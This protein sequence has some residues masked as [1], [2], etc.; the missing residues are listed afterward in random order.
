MKISVCIPTYEA[1]GKGVE[2][3][4]KNIQ[5]ILDQTYKNIEIVVSDHS[6]DD[7]IENYVKSIDSENIKYLRYTENIGYP[8]YNTNNAIKNASGDY[9]KLMNLD[10]F[11]IGEESIQLMVDLINKGHKWVLSSFLHCNYDDK[12]LV[13]PITPSLGI[14]TIVGDGKHLIKGINYIGCPSVALIPRDEY[15]DTEVIYMID[16]E[17]WYRLYLKYGYPGVVKNYSIGIGVGSHTLT[18]QLSSKREEW[19]AKDIEY[20]NKKY[21]V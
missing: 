8:S 21:L 9:I 13:K 5:S 1:N 20:C 14:P 10:D 2:F 19:L 3:L 4:S 18:N 17:L 16:C 15:F 7:E 6:K 12:T 11:I